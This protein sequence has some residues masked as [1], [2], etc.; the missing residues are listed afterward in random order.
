M[1]PSIFTIDTSKTNKAKKRKKKAWG[2]R[3]RTRVNDDEVGA[4]LRDELGRNNGLEVI[5][6]N[7]PI[8]ETNRKA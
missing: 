6:I 2:K 1:C 8:A 3:S 7:K 5:L 4:A